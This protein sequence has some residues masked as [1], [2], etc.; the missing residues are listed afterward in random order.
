MLKSRFF[1][2]LSV[3]LDDF[4]QTF[5]KV[6]EHQNTKRSQAAAFQSDL[7]DPTKRVL[8]ID[9]A[10]AYQCELQNETMGALWT[11]GSVNLFTCAVYRNSETNTLIFGTNYKGKD[12]FSTGLFIETLY[13]DYILPN[14]TVEEEVILSD[15]P[16]SEFKNQFMCFL[17]EKLSNKYKKYFS[18]KFSATS[19]G[20]GVVDGVGGR[21]KASV[22]EKV[23]SLGKERIIVQ[24][25]ESFCQLA[26]QLTKRTTVIHVSKEEIEAYKGKNPFSDSVPVKG[27]F[28]TH[29]MRSNGKTTDLW[30]N[31]AYMKSDPPCIS[32]VNKSLEISSTEPTGPSSP[33]T[34]ASKG[35]QPFIYHD[36]VKVVKGNY[37]GYYG[38]ITETGDLHDLEDKDEIEINYLRKSFG[39]WVVN[40]NDLDSREIGELA[41]VTATVDGR[42]RYTITE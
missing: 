27:I 9:Y 6:K 34:L 20:K 3:L 30:L 29:V 16:T 17:I 1:L 15:G 5:S 35:K 25:A 4:Q 12:K 38:I 8:Q 10:Q 31:S 42:S 33:P 11:R 22:H 14:D 19:H 7:N 18:W 28:K 13:K 32:I 21:I 37:V 23:M 24:D 40:E 26:K 41:S 39:K 2:R 36:V